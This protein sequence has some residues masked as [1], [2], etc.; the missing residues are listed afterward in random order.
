MP[1]VYGL[2]VLITFTV[3][4]TVQSTT[5][6]SYNP[7]RLPFSVWPSSAVF[8]TGL[9]YFPFLLLAIYMSNK[10]CNNFYFMYR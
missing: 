8:S 4:C 2:V 3:N 5:Y 10:K 1:V 6:Q 9:I 7:N